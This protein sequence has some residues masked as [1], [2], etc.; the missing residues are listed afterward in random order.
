MRLVIFSSTFLLFSLVLPAQVDVP[1]SQYNN[2]RTGANLAERV[3]TPRHVNGREFG[4]LRTLHVDGDVYAQPLFVSAVSI[5]GNGVRDLVFIAT[6]HDS[7]YAFDAAAQSAS[8]IWVVHFADAAKHIMPSLRKLSA[9]R[10]SCLNWASR[11]P[12]SSIAP[13]TLFAYSL[14]RKKLA[15]A[16][17]Q[18]IGSAS[19]LSISRPAK[20]N[21]AA[22]L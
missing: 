14:A 2:S 12:R 17:K 6:E 22:R 13:P 7:V 3:L 20:R 9:A 8:L 16:E 11:L 10:L 19:T 5:P 15:T 21:S 4:K 18:S 1:T